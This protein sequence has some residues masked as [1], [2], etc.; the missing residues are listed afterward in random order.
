MTSTK[1]RLRMCALAVLACAAAACGD[2]NDPN[3]PGDATPGT[4]AVLLVERVF[5]PSGRQYVMSVLPDVPTAG[6]DRSTATVLDSADIELFEGKAYVRDRVANTM[7]RY[8]V[9][10]DS[11]LEMNGQFSFATLGLAANRYNNAFVS[12]ERAYLMDSTEWRLIGWNPTTMALTGEVVSIA[13]MKKDPAL[14]GSISSAVAVGSRLVASI[15]W[16]DFTNLI[17]FPGSGLLVIDPAAPSAPVFVEDA[18]VGG[19]FRV[20]AAPNGDA[21]LTGTVSGDFRKFGSAFGGGALPASGLVKLAAGQ[22]A[23]D[24]SYLVD[25][26]AITQTKAVG[27][28]HRIDDTTLLA[29]IYDPAQEL[30]PTLS[31]FR[32]STEFQFVFIDTVNRTMTPVASLPKGGQ[33][34]A[35]NHVVDGKL[36]IQ[37]SN[38]TGS[39]AYAVSGTGVTEAFPVPAGDVWF[40]ARI[41]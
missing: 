22:S 13:A 5:T 38:A 24:A 35:G 17:M 26:E 12:A 34:N 3:P 19:G 39:V 1:N 2:G 18:R 27:A 4:P 25:I 29:Q 23:P 7:T 6:V 31:E 36:Y 41:R 10:A 16:A 32:A 21:Y 14:T 37:L 11:K 40:L 20:T 33:A 9:T 15:N 30:P 8:E 28:I